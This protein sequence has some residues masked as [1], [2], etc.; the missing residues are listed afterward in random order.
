MYNLP[1]LTGMA[2]VNAYSIQPQPVIRNRYSFDIDI[3]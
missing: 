3:A 2:I 1:K